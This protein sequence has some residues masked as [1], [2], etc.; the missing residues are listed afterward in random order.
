MLMLWRIFCLL[1]SI[2]FSNSY[3]FSLSFLLLS[4]CLRKKKGV[5]L[6]PFYKSWRQLNSVAWTH[7]VHILPYICVHSCMQ[8]KHVTFELSFWSQCPLLHAVL[9]DAFVYLCCSFAY[10]H[11]NVFGKN[12]K[13]NISL[14]RGQIDSIFRVNYTDPWIEGDDKRTSRTIM[15]QVIFHFLAS[16][17][18]YFLV[19][20]CL[21]FCEL[22]VCT[23]IQEPLAILFM[24]IAV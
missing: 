14:E 10:S 17:Y 3:F 6:L 8:Y 16:N 19:I 4:T 11:R 7:N 15:I 24:V 13:L 22:I 23:R 1:G 12:Q 21:F 2:S 18:N 9:A 5:C 20:G